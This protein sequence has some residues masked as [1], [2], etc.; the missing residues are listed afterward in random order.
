MRRG[1][2]IVR[3][4]KGRMD[5]IGPWGLRLGAAGGAPLAAPQRFHPGEVLVE[6]EPAFG[7]AEEE[8]A[9]C[10]TAEDFD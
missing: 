10:S 4:E 8:L 2:A 1:L 6:D 5:R 7:G 3:G 9:S